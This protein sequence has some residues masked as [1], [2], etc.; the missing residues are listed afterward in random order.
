MLTPW[1]AWRIS[2]TLGSIV[3]GIHGAWD[4]G[5]RQLLFVGDLLQLPLIVKNIALPVSRRMIT[6]LPC[7]PQIH[8][9]ILRE[10]Y[11]CENLQWAKFL[12]N[13]ATGSVEEIQFWSRCENSFIYT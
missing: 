8:K 6:R 11:R 7:W 9:F 10:Q 1:V 3:G 2:R 5:G 13:V 4:F 12:A